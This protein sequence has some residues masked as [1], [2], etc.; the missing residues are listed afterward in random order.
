[1]PIGVGVTNCSGIGNTNVF[2]DREFNYLPKKSKIGSFDNYGSK[3]RVDRDDMIKD[4]E[5]QKNALNKKAYNAFA[6][7]FGT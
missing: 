2:M 3:P 5:A 1:M 4:Y 6:E 7:R